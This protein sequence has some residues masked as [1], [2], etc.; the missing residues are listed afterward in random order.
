MQLWI[1]ID[2]MPTYV[3]EKENKR[4]NTALFF[5]S[6]CSAA[7]V[8]LAKIWAAEAVDMKGPLEHQKR[9]KKHLKKVEILM[10]TYMKQNVIHNNK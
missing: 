7:T 8:Y 1:Q 6:Q 3:E 2:I 10:E 5:T 4:L 9:A